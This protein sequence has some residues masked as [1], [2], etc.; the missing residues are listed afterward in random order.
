M[1]AYQ[2]ESETAKRADVDSGGG[3]VM[4]RAPVS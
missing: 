3:F 1:K 2:Q 4:E